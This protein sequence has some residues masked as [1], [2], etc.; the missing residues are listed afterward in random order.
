MHSKYIVPTALVL[1]ALLGLGIFF[2]LITSDGRPKLISSLHSPYRSVL[3]PFYLTLGEDPNGAAVN[4]QTPLMEASSLC[5]LKYVKLLLS[6]GAN[7]NLKNKAGE[8][9]LMLVGFNGTDESTRI[10]SELINAGADVDVVS[11]SGMTALK[12]A[13]KLGD[14]RLVELIFNSSKN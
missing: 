3:F 11:K 13:K 10:A 2:S 8:T 5:S 14:N 12:N 9:A 1:L 4:G 6:S 7:P